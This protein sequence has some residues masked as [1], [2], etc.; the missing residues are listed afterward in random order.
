[1]EVLS[2]YVVVLYLTVFVVTF[3]FLAG[4]ALPLVLASTASASPL[5]PGIFSEH[6]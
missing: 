4:G 5:C 6:T 1:M 3:H 2:T